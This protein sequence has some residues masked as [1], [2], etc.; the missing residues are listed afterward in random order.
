MARLQGEVSVQI[1]ISSNGHVVSAAASGTAHR[2]LQRQAEEDIRSWTFS[3]SC[4]GGTFPQKQV[5]V[6]AY[7]HRGPEEYHERPPTV[8][9]HLPYRLEIITHPPQRE[10]SG[11][12]GHP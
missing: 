1:Y 3:V 12:G 8:V 6:F 2:F 4:L 7:K 9:L 11:V 5:V 10:T